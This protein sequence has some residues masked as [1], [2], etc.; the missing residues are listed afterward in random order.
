MTISRNQVFWYT[1]TPLDVLM[2]RDAKP[3]I[4]EEQACAGSTLLPNTPTNVVK[5][6]LHNNLTLDSG[7]P[8]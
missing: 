4:P 1:I 5:E 2:F 8:L 3:F 6:I 7:D